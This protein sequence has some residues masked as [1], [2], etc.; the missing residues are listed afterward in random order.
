M[1]MRTPFAIISGKGSTR[2][3]TA[4]FWRQR[5]TGLANIPLTLFLVWLV[6]RLAG[7]GRDE[8]IVVISN[9]LVAGLVILALVA[10]FWH[11]ALGLQVV[12]EDYVHGEG[13]KI[14][15]IILNKFFTGTIGIISILAVLKLSFGG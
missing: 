15:L 14:F 10:M 11:M 13:M 8:M 4:H 7:A 5:L 2:D 6:I 12:I 3:G 9:P 1:D